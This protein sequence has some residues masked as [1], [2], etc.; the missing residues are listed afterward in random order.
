MAITI[1]RLKPLKLAKNSSIAQ[2]LSNLGFICKG[3][4]E[5]KGEYINSGA[6]TKEVL[7]RQCSLTSVSIIYPMLKGKATPYTLLQF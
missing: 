2:N 3:C 6:N 5:K 4:N 7:A 1:I